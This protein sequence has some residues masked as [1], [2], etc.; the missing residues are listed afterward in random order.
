[1]RWKIG[2]LL[3]VASVVLMVIT[4]TEAIKRVTPL[5]LHEGRV[6]ARSLGFL[7]TETLLVL[8]FLAGRRLWR[9]SPAELAEA[10]AA[11]RVK[12]PR[13]WSLYL[14]LG[15]AFLVAMFATFL[16]AWLGFPRPLYFLIEGPCV[17][18]SAIL[19]FCVLP[20]LGSILNGEGVFVA[21]H[22][23]YFLALFYPLYRMSTTDR[24]AEAVRYQRM[25]V[26][27]VLFMIIHL[28]TAGVC[29]I[30]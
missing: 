27:L 17:F 14:Y 3:I 28:S 5:S 6:M 26:V 12:R 20:R 23:L 7:L 24:V 30:W 4:S 8:V 22:V 11:A 1:V 13:P 25:K 18:I 10:V 21:I 2:G 29:I 9:R 15:G 16:P 19:A